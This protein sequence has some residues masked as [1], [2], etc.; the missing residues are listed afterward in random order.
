MAAHAPEPM[1][2]P[3][4]ATGSPVYWTTFPAR[5]VP[6]DWSEPAAAH[7]A[8]MRL[9]PARLP[10]PAHERR[11]A[12]AILFRL[13]NVGGEL[14]VLIQSNQMPESIPAEGRAMTVTDR[15]WDTEAG[16]L[17]AFRVA[18]NPVIRGK[19][20][21]EVQPDKPRQR[22]SG[23]GP[24]VAKKDR[25]RGI[26]A[27]NDLPA[28]LAARLGDS[29]TN[30]TIVN[31]YREVYRTP[32]QRGRTRSLTIDTVDA[33]AEVNNPE[34]LDRLRREGVGR[35]RAYGCGLITARPAVVE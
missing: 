21:L 20:T 17:I 24:V 11:A 35:S 8:V 13:D 10:G 29:V 7:R 34:T 15:G 12:A 30:V 23:N 27:P 16:D 31:H 26:V 25:T 4:T 33:I 5:S 14:T 28:W 32:S 3:G 2:E 18:V 9:F 19:V 22:R 1:T 6:V